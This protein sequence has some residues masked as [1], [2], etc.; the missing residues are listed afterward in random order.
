[1]QWPV[2]A[3]LMLNRYRHVETVYQWLA[4]WTNYPLI[5]PVLRRNDGEKHLSDRK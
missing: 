5:D 3:V 2:Y 4:E 1:M